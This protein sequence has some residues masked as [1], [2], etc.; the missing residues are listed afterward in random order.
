MEIHAVLPRTPQRSP[1]SRTISVGYLRS[2]NEPVV[3]WII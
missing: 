2:L 1:A 3:R